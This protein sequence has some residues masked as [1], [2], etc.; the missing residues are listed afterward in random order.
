MGASGSGGL[1]AGDF[2]GD[3]NTD[4]A[5]TTSTGVAVLLGNG[6]GTFHGPI[7]SVPG[8]PQGG[9][10][11]ADFNGDGITDL[12]VI[13]PQ[14]LLILLGNGDGT[15]GVSQNLAG[16]GGIVTA[17]FNGDGKAD[18]AF[19]ASYGL[20]VF[21]GKGDGTFVETPSYGYPLV[22]SQLI[23]LAVGDFNGDGNP[24]LV[25]GAYVAIPTP[26]L[27]YTTYV[28][29]VLVFLGKGDG[30][31]VQG[32]PANSATYASAY[33]AAVT[34]I[35][36]GDINGDGKA[37]IAVGGGVYLGQ[38]DGT[39]GPGLYSYCNSVN[40]AAVGNFNGDGS[41][42]VVT[43]S[44]APANPAIGV[45]LGAFNAGAGANLTFPLNAS[46]YDR[47]ETL[48][49]VAAGA[50]RMVATNGEVNGTGR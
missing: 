6:D 11:A 1:V 26:S 31:L 46:V 28:P 45:R 36:V 3:G 22:P 5:L 24:D 19:I 2:N 30:T 35:E 4:L 38:G 18:L 14:Q 48:E 9:I 39:F 49:R 21:L 7:I 29:A 20:H 25:I 43:T 12:A 42:D 37:D 17:D 40:V 34:A 10:V 27:A 23:S 33:P 41:T 50:R 13:G 44:G 16:G 32:P 47:S 8:A 15:F